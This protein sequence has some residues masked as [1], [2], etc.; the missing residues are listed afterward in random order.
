MIPVARS[1]PADVMGNSAIFAFVEVH[2]S[3]LLGGLL[4]CTYDPETI[5]IMSM[6]EKA[7]MVMRMTQ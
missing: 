7:S 5:S 3:S 1:G 4:V 6:L 2:R